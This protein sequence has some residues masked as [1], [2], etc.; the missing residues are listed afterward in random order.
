MSPWRSDHEGSAI[1][2][3]AGVAFLLHGD[4]QL[5]SIDQ[6]DSSQ[7]T[8]RRPDEF[9]WLLGDATDL[10]FYD[11]IEP[12]ETRGLL[13]FACQ[14]EVALDIALILLDCDL[15]ETVRKQ[16]AEDLED[17]F[18]VLKV[19]YAVEAVLYAAPLPDDADSE[20][21]LRFSLA[22]KQVYA[23]IKHLRDRQPDIRKVRQ[24]W[25]SVE[26]EHFGGRAERRATRKPVRPRWTLS[27]SCT[28]SG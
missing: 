22:K 9:S 23:F 20:N 28:S 19:R 6:G 15:P 18:S 12:R 27:Q 4:G 3:C 16:A 5:F 24:A 26:D 1:R 13:D 25:E 17:C 21:A 7:A 8:P 2:D 11:D 10:E 14:R